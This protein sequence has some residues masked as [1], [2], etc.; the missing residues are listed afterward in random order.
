[1]S[2]ANPMN[3][4]CS[5]PNGTLWQQQPREACRRWLAA[6]EQLSYAPHSIAQYA[7][8]IGHAADWLLQHRGCDLL[9]TQASDLDALL[10]SLRGR[11][12]KP[13]SNATLKRYVAVLRLVLTH[14]QALELRRP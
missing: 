6:H 5:A 14:L 9:N 7:A 13:A 2:F 4:D 11:G 3:T 8:M 12:D 1:M 10:H